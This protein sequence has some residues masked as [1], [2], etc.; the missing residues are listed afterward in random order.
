[1]LEQADKI[2]GHPIGKIGVPGLFCPPTHQTV[3]V[4]PPSVTL[5]DEFKC[6][7]YPMKRT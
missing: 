3:S 5:D 4:D 1:M 6:T 7:E 2:K